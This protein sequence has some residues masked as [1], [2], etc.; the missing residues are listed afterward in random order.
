MEVDLMKSEQADISKK[1]SA[2]NYEIKM[3]N[4][5]F[6]EILV[7]LETALD[8]IEDCGKAYRLADEHTKRLLN[9]A[10]FKKFKIYCDDNEQVLIEPELTEPFDLILEPVKQDI[11]LIESAKDKSA[12]ELSKAL[13]NAIRHIKEFFECGGLPN[14][15]QTHSN[16]SNFFKPNSSSKDLLVDL[17]GI[18]P[19]SEN[20]SPKVSSIIVFILTFPP[21][22]V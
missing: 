13:K 1:L 20:L 18:E 19:A 8:L 5:T 4:T 14:A 21:S 10:I 3:H 6:D 11:Q 22:G 9:Q 16:D 2:I 7:N 12:E 15:I 17:A